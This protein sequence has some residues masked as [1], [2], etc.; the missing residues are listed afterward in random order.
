MAIPIHNTQV[1]QSGLKTTS[2]TSRL[3]DFLARDF[4]ETETTRLTTRLRDQKINQCHGT[5]ALVSLAP[6]DTCMTYVF[7]RGCEIFR[8]HTADLELFSAYHN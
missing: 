4:R 1:R 7:V 2:A 8:T 5:V 3:R 6:L